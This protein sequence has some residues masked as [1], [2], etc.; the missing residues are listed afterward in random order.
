MA[1]MEAL[2]PALRVIMLAP[3]PLIVIAV[4]IIGNSL[5]RLIVPLSPG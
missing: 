5:V 4:P 3:G 2:F 1:E